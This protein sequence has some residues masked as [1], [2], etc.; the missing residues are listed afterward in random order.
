MNAWSSAPAGLRH[1]VESE[2]D[3]LLDL[4]GSM[5]AAE[6]STPTPA[7]GWCVR[8]V[9]LHL[10]D[11]DLG[12]LS[13]DRDGDLSSLI[14]MS[15]EYRAFVRA[16]DQKNQ[17]W[18]E[19]ARGLSKRVVTDL[20]TWSGA[21]VTAYYRTSEAIEPTGVVWA[22]RQ[23]PSWLGIGRDFTERWV[24]Q[25]QIR[26]AVRHPGHHDRY[27]PIVLSVFVWAFPHQYRTHARPGTTIDLDFGARAHWHLERGDGG[28]EL[29]DGP[30]PAPAAGL[31][32]DMDAA[33][34]QLTGAGGAES[35]VT[36]VG[37]AELTGP[38]LDVRG[39]IV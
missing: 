13:R 30:A 38:L 36:T 5:T 10:L 18:V 31:V 4:L 20:L 9:A 8:D 25:Q 2:R 17:R 22:G 11:D 1:A 15:G 28:W 6:W 7:P 14:P 32:T 19:A 16:L 37:P 24:H 35:T 33:W 3:E 12:W 34:R 39:I 26:E 27:L 23:A 29:R 21:E